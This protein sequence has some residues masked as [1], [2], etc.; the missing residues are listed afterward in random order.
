[1]TL[2]VARYL[3]GCGSTSGKGKNLSLLQNVE[4]G[5]DIRLTLQF[6]GHRVLFVLAKQIDAKQISHLHL[7]PRLRMSGAIPL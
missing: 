7:L 4:T 2:F 5:S 6:S 3:S 1:M